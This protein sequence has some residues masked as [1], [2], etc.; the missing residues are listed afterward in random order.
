M[1]REEEILIL[2]LYKEVFF[3]NQLLVGQQYKG[4]LWFVLYRGKRYE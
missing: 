3:F 4:V 1:Y 2:M